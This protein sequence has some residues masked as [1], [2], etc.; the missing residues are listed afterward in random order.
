MRFGKRALAAVLAAAVLISG[1]SANE[2]A[3]M[4]AIG[5]NF[6]E[7]TASGVDYPESASSENSSDDIRSGVVDNPLKNSSDSGS[8]SGNQGLPDNSNGDNSGNGSSDTQSSWNSGNTGN[9]PSGS[10]PTGGGTSST[11]NTVEGEKSTGKFN[12]GEALQ[13]SILFYELQR[14]GDID[15]KTAR[16]NWRGDSGMNDGADV[17]LDLTGGLYDAGDNVKFNLP[18]AYTATMLSWSVYEDKDAYVKS[19]QL[20]Y[21]LGNIKWICDYLIKCHPSAD[22]YYYQVGDG[23]ADHAWW[24]PA[25][26][27]QM[28]RPAFKVDKNSPG[29]TVSGEAAAAL[30]ACSVVFKDIDKSYSEKCLTHAKQLYNFADSTKSDAGYTAANGF[31]SSF[32][33]F[34]DEL[35]WGAVWLYIATG[36]KSYL[37]KAD[38]YFD[39]F[40]PDYKWTLGWDNKFYGAACLLANITNGDK[41]KKALEK[42]LDWWCGIGGESITYSPKGLAWLDSW[43]SLRYAANAAFLAGS[44]VDGGNCPASKKAAYTKLLE[45]QIDY[46]LGSSGRSYVVGYGVNPPEHP[47]H[48]TAQGSWANNMSEP[49]YHRHVLYGALVGGPDASDNYSDTVSDYC[50]NEVACDYN[51]GFTGA[52]AKMYKKYGG[53]TLK[54][55]G[56]VE[57]VGEELY[58]EY[59]TNATGSD[60]TEIKAMVYNKTGWPA[61]V[62][63]NLELRYFVDLSEVSDPSAVTVSM[64]YNDGAKFG[65]IYEWNKAENI[66]YVSIDFSGVKIY[67]GGQSEYK[68]EVQFRMS[69]AGW[70]PENDPSYKELKGSNGSELVRAVSMG[71]Y[72]GGTLVFGSEPDGKAVNTKPI[73]GGSNSSSSSSS[74][75]NSVAQSSSQPAKPTGE[76]NGIRVNLSQQQTSGSANTIKLA[77]DLT[78]NTGAAIELSGLEIDYFFTNDGDNDLAF[79]CDYAALTGGSYSALTSGVSGNFSAASGENC[80]TKCALKFSSGTLQNGD[81]MTVQGR[82]CRKNWTNFNLSNDYSSGNAE[83]LYII[84]GGK[85]IFGSKP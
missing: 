80:D 42:N 82:I 18:M 6:P 68:K 26:V 4:D 41:Y 60:F 32:S 10:K 46:A 59:R 44:Y 21:A 58:V 62:T 56:A 25:E 11:G 31:Y 34:Y 23:N 15:E 85:P 55:F 47:H 53:Q 57:Q 72:E 79:F 49:N 71:L 29:S 12:Y 45:T 27:M 33:G 65:G 50:K 9:S 63:D 35:I 1:C 73:S 78:N 52:L 13:K 19:G 67:P 2:N 24:G 43:G 30:A 14:S 70:D 37:T 81:S 5:G 75:S 17:G 48:R 38:K 39:G 84:S 20:D 54:N 22:V 40:E 66:Y 76:N 28:N 51:A 61:R 3:S 36:D 7:S 8:S 77:I 16:C 83:R 64:N 74:S 69:A